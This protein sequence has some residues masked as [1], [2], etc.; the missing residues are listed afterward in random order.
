MQEP[1]F[2]FEQRRLAN[3]KSK[4]ASPLTLR[5]VEKTVLR[6]KFGATELTA[7]RR[8][9]VVIVSVLFC[10]SSLPAQTVVSLSSGGTA[11]VKA[12]GLVP[13]AVVFLHDRYG[14]DAWTRSLCDSLA[15]EGFCMLAVDLY[16]GKV[17][18]DFMEAHEIERA[19]PDAQVRADIDAAFSY[20]AKNFPMIKKTAIVGL[21]MGGGY[22]LETALRRR[23]ISAVGIT[24][25]PIV[26]SEE[27]VQKITAPLFGS[28][29]GSDIG[30][31]S[32]R[33]VK[34]RER[35]KTLGRTADVKIYPSLKHDFMRPS[36]ENFSDTFNGAAASDAWRRLIQFLSTFLNS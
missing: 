26:E 5:N 13:S 29:A 16:R 9:F 33:V 7:M 31:D 23:D 15:R 34:F 4:H 18:E 32:A 14:L 1:R 27:L 8:L 20:L 2:K 3:R 24:Y 30:I 19:L 21:G 22:A 28:F 36:R 12:N 35:L 11:Y 6:C 17:P 10:A 25:A